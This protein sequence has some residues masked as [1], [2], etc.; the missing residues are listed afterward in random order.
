MA[1]AAA[2][3]AAAGAGAGAAAAVQRGAGA[4]RASRRVSEVGNG[5]AD[6][7]DITRAGR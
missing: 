2:G 7:H 4:W 5:P 6:R 1:A 3:A